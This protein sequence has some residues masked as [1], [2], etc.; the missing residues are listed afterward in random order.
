MRIPLTQCRNQPPHRSAADPAYSGTTIRL[1]ASNPWPSTG[2]PNGQTT[3]FRP[4]YGPEADRKASTRRPDRQGQR[5]SDRDTTPSLPHGGAG[6]FSQLHYTRHLPP[7]PVAESEPEGFSSDDI[8]PN[9]SEALLAAFGSC[10]AIGIHANAIARNIPIRRLA[11]ELEAD[12][13]TTAVSGTGDIEPKPIGFETVRVSVTIDADASRDS[14]DALIRHA[15][16]CRRSPIR[17]TIRCTWTSAWLP[18]PSP[19]RLAGE[20]A[21][22]VSTVTRVASDAGED[23]LDPY[24]GWGRR[25]RE[26]RPSL[27][28]IRSD[29]GMRT[30]S[31]T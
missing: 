3:R 26:R 30:V 25:S 21:S 31:M 20:P 11:L 16:L 29:Q 4:R 12:I 17:S 10:L 8:A 15:T 22:M 24:D 19:R 27:T 14:L 2:R 7:Q 9:T 28:E 1:A 13:N 23:R 5:R 18:A 6:A